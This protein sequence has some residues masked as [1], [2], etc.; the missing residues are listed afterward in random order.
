MAKEITLEGVAAG[1]SA[2]AEKVSALEG[3]VAAATKEA[4]LAKAGKVA[5]ADAKQAA[6]GAA[7][8]ATKAT[9]VAM[10][11]KTAFEAVSKSVEDIRQQYMNNNNNS[12]NSTRLELLELDVEELK[13]ASKSESFLT[14]L[15]RWLVS[16]LDPGK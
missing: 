16:W 13:K 3:L 15:R 8:E 6:L 12:I 7:A 1:L 9:Q 10:A 14:R 4:Q 11:A 2:L 5:L